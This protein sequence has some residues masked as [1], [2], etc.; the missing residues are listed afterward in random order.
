[1]RAA[2]LYATEEPRL[3]IRDDVEV[4]GPGAGEVLVRLRAAGVC[5]S[6]VSTR[7]GYLPGVMRPFSG[8]RLPAR[9]LPSARG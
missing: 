5:H 7:N 6:D 1:M 3:D 4:I 2:V 8:T 9:S